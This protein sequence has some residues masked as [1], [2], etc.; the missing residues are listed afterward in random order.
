MQSVL[1]SG[2]RPSPERS[3]T[4]RREP[5]T[6]SGWKTSSPER[7]TDTSG[8]LDSDDKPDTG[9][10]CTLSKQSR[11]SPAR[12]LAREHVHRLTLEP[13][14]LLGNPMKKRT[15]PRSTRLVTDLS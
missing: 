11:K 5:S 14:R 13:H 2:S 3:D 4:P 1:N 12:E 6:S 7:P 8:P 15:T 9:T 10:S